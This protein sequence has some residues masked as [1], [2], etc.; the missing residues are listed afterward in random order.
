MTSDNKRF[1]SFEKKQGFVTYGDNNK[2]RIMGTGNIGGGSTLT[3]KDVLYVEGLKHNLLSISQLCDKGFK[4]RR[5]VPCTASFILSRTTY[6]SVG[7]LKRNVERASFRRIKIHSFR[8]ITT[9]SG[10]RGFTGANA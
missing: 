6:S 3:I 9:E 7:E 8:T 2:G 4:H 10:R 1:I 5:N